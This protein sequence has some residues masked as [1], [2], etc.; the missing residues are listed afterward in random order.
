MTNWGCNRPFSNGVGGTADDPDVDVA[1][2][3]DNPNEGFTGLED[4]LKHRL[5]LLPQPALND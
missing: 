3:I 1:E 4:T 2:D 5:G